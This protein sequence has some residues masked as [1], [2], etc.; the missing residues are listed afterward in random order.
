MRIRTLSGILTLAL[1]V[2][3]L[4]CA[5]HLAI[6]VGIRRVQYGIFGDA[7]RVA[8]GKVNADLL[9]AGSSRATLQYSPAILSRATGLTT[10][11]LG[12]VGSQKSV[13]TGTLRFYLRRNRPPRLLVENVDIS[14]LNVRDALY[15]V[16]QYTPYLYDSGLYEALHRRYPEI[17]KARYL[18]LYG[19]VAN[20]VEFRHYVGLKALF[21]I[22]PPQDYQDG[23]QPYDGKWTGVI[24]GLKANQKEIRYGTDPRGIA[25]FEDFLSEAQSRGIPTI[26]VFSPMYH[27]HL[28]RVAD[29]AQIMATFAEL[30]RRHGAEFWDMSDLAPFSGS[31]SYFLDSLHLNL[32]GATAFSEV[33]GQRLAA[34]LVGRHPESDR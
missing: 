20:D 4:A 9:V 13:Q 22:Q 32:R 15:D 17:W 21:G 33:L 6:Y 19:Y 7:N 28:A 23:Y 18:P 11:N 26:L 27:E 1:A 24:A 29:R 12:R 5:L 16:P 34:W 30:A 3:L 25:D 10:F 31:T 14:D 8:D 2:G